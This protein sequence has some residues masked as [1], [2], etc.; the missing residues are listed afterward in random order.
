MREKDKNR[1]LVRAIYYNNIVIIIK[2]VE[3]GRRRDEGMSLRDE[4]S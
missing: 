2:K 1:A 3:G 4:G